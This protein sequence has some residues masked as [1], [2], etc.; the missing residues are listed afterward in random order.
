ME[1]KDKVAVKD[2]GDGR[3]AVAPQAPAEPAVRGSTLAAPR[4]AVS[5]TIA[6]ERRTLPEYAQRV[7]DAHLIAN[8]SRALNEQCFRHIHTF[9]PLTLTFANLRA[10]SKAFLTLRGDQAAIW[11]DGGGGDRL[12]GLSLSST[13]D[14][15]L[16]VSNFLI[17]AREMYLQT[18]KDIRELQILLYLRTE[19]NRVTGRVDLPPNASVTFQSRDDRSTVIGL[20][21]FAIALGRDMD[22]RDRT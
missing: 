17:N 8:A 14:P 15:V 18:Y 2:S 16:Y 19:Q 12:V 9:K 7:V 3:T 1:K 21:S 13:V 6:D 22:S 5:Q 11:S 20:S 10:N 4:E